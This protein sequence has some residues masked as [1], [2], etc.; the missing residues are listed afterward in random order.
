MPNYGSDEGLKIAQCVSN[1]NDAK[2]DVAKFRKMFAGKAPANWRSY[3]KYV[4]EVVV[5][6]PKIDGANAT[7]NVTVHQESNYE[8]IATKEGVHQGRGR[9]EDHIRSTAVSAPAAQ[10]GRGWI[11]SPVFDLLFLANL[12]WLLLLVPGFGT[13]SD[14]VVDFWQLYFLTLPHRWITLILVLTDRDRRGGQD[15]KLA[16]IAVL[17][18]MLVVGAY[19]GTGAF[20]CLAM[21]DYLWN[22]WH[23]ASQHAGVLR[24][25]SRKVG[26]GI[27]WLERWG[28]RGFV[29]YGAVRAAGWTTGWA[30][31]GSS[32][33]PWLHA[34]D[35]LVLLVPAALIVTN[36]VGATRDRLG[37]LA[38]LGSVC[39]L[40]VGFV[41]SL[42]C[43]WVGGIIAFA[44]AGSMFH[45][46]EYLAIVTH[47]ARRRGSTGSDSPFRTLAGY[48]LL[49]LGLYV[50]V[51]GTLGVWMSDPSNGVA[52]FWQGLNLW[53]AFVH[54]AYDGMIWKLRR[55]ETAA[56]L[57]VSTS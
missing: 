43:G 3:D 6:S 57:G 20:L 10:A 1:F 38:Y 22:A 50:L 54:Y 45:A 11:V 25:Y 39:A 23:F 2:G 51:L 56:A 14:T 12:G 27:E 17:A 21:L 9:V 42:R 47:Y 31:A 41:L 19:F 49:F 28:V 30:E 33:L 37:K 34:F 36:L 48:W 24:M 55:P 52:V 26:G 13:R 44:A 46:V 29:T 35:L 40:Y 7:A 5:G 15:R 8:V 32:W 16:V 4:Y 18:A 53:A